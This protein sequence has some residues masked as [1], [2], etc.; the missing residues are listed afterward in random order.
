MDPCRW[1][2]LPVTMCHPL[3]TAACFAARQAII[4]VPAVF[5]RLDDGRL[6]RCA[7]GCRLCYL[8]RM[9]CYMRRGCPGPHGLVVLPA[10][11]AVLHACVV[12]VCVWCG[13][14]EGCRLCYLHRMLCYMRLGIQALIGWLCYQASVLCCMRVRC[15]CC[16]YP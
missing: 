1:V 8:H 11:H 3:G 2:V 9:L 10:L 4:L 6:G 12:S 14:P 16:V 7:Q 13:A 15:V 5:V